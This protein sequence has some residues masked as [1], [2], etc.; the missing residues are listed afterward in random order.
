M[1]TVTYRY[2]Y[3]I[4]NEEKKYKIIIRKNIGEIIVYKIGVRINIMFGKLLNNR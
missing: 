2:V 1:L 3:L 4:W